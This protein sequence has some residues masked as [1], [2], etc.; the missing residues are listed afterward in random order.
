MVFKKQA[1]EQGKYVDNQ[2]VRFD[3]LTCERTESKE[4]YETGEIDENEGPI[5][6]Q[7][8]VINKGWDVFAD[9]A[10]AC[11]AYGLSEVE[12]GGTGD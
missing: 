1:N 8:L 4:W 11:E 9:L 10:A 6:A 7:R 3:V 2:G 5:M 12:N